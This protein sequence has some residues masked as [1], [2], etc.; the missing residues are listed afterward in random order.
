[1]ATIASLKSPSVSSNEL[2]RFC[3]SLVG[4][5]S[6]PPLLN[7]ALRE[8]ML[9]GFLLLL[10][11][12]LHTIVWLCCMIVLAPWLFAFSYRRFDFVVSPRISL[13]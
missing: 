11:L 13:G 4:P 5:Q 10:L 2:H 1:M 12:V 9:E 6:S 7:S 3:D 8:L